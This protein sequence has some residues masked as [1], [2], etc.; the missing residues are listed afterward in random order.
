MP[1]DFQREGVCLAPCHLCKQNQA[2]PAPTVLGAPTDRGAPVHV[3][4]PASI[5]EAEAQCRNKTTSLYSSPVEATHGGLAFLSKASVFHHLF[6]I[7][8]LL[9][10]LQQ[11]E[12]IISG[13]GASG[14]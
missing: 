10:Q 1:N 13:L 4:L 9:N 7:A 3:G 5:G 12:G 6:F 14:C 2:P 11:M 8:R